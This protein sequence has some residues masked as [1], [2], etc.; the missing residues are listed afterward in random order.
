MLKFRKNIKLQVIN[1]MVVLESND[2]IVFRDVPMDICQKF[3]IL[4]TMFEHCEDDNELVPVPNVSGEILEKVIQWARHHK[5]D[6]DVDSVEE[7]EKK[8][9]LI[10]AWD[11]EFFKVDQ[12]ILFDM[13]LAANFLDFKQLLHV[14]CQTVAN[15]M[16][17]K[18]ADEIRVLFNIKK[19]GTREQELQIQKENEWCEKR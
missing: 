16:K 15:M 7:S 8:T 2:G 12:G 4:K 11:E 9:T 17:G 3:T 14:V 13:I 10:T 1:S 18:T 6:A 5:D 19:D